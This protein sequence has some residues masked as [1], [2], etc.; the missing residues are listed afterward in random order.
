MV[1]LVVAL[2]VLARRD[3]A[4]WAWGGVVVAC[5]L[6]MV[7]TGSRAAWGALLVAGLVATAVVLRTERSEWAALRRV[8][9]RALPFAL[10]AVVAAVVALTA[11]GTAR[12]T[13]PENVRSYTDT[14]LYT[15][16]L[17]LPLADRLK[18]RTEL[19]NAAGRMVLDRPLTGIGIGRY[20]KDVS[21]YA[22]DS[23]ELIRPQENAHNYF[24]QV[25][26]E[27][28]LPGLLLLV[29][30]VTVPLGAALRLARHQAAPPVTRIIIGAAAAGLLAHLLTWLTGHPLLIRDGQISFWPLVALVLLGAP[31]LAVADR[32]VAWPRW[33]VAT[34][35][36]A[37][38]VSVPF[39]AAA[40]VARVDLSR[41][42]VGVYDVER[43]A[44]GRS[45]RWTGERAVLYVP[46][47]ARSFTL[48]VRALAPFAQ[49]VDVRSD[50]T[51]VDRLSLTDHSWR[52]FRYQLRPAAVTRRFHRFELHVSP[53][54]V[55][56]SRDDRTLGIVLGH[57]SWE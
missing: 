18:G 23:A 43:D 37:V 38:M 30:L 51:L 56:A 15:F 8:V 35:A 47:T 57:W 20:Y 53:T 54:W 48:E 33:A 49:T 41:T 40:E 29:S 21:A 16:N 4:R 17:R 46:A 32:R 7:F 45:F 3:E 27:L 25:A 6:S 28:G 31:P 36:C 26:A 13:R 12:N 55:P 44:E 42:P 50:G 14:L 5:L 1:P 52:T 11:L 10:A 39:R 9:S 2:A 24:L 22:P 19:W 34:A